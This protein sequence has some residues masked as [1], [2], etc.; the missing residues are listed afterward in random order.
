MCDTAILLGWAIFYGSLTVLLGALAF[1][2][3]LA[4]VLVFSEER[5]LE[6]KFGEEYLRY[7]AAVPRW[8]GKT[9]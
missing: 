6:A 5:K 3:F 9:N 1:G 2:A 7:K 4:F 8:L